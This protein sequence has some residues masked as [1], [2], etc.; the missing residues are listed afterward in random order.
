MVKNPPVN[1]GDSGSIP[2]SRRSHGQGNGNPVQYFGLGNP[3]DRG[4]WWAIV[5]GVAK[6]DGYDLVTRQQQIFCQYFIQSNPSICRIEVKR[7]L[8]THRTH[9]RPSKTKTPERRDAAVSQPLVW[10]PKVATGITGDSDSHAQL[11]ERGPKHKWKI[12]G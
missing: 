2:G 1:T 3:I 9:L 7:F 6:E 12:T 11:Q 10:K 4:V 5:H 8:P